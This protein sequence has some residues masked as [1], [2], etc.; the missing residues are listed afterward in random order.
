MPVSAERARAAPRDDVF[1][2]V[3][4]G[5]AAPGACSDAARQR[6]PERWRVSHGLRAAVGGG[7]E[8]GGGLKGI[9]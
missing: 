6:D 3:L 9:E 7:G 4:N 1:S 2:C 8:G 5:D